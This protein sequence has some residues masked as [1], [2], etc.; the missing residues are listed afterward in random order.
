MKTKDKTS[1]RDLLGP[2][3]EATWIQSKSFVT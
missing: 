3:S 2:K 1:V